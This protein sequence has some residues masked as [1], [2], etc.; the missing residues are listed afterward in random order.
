M[1]RG[2]SSSPRER[3]GEGEESGRGDTDRYL[4]LVWEGSGSFKNGS[5]SGSSG[6]VASLVE[7]SHFKNRLAK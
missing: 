3:G 4:G 7:L 2:T 5:G 6:G 1:G